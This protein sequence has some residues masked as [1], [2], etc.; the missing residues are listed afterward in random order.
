MAVIILWSSTM[1]HLFTRT[2]KI[3][4]FDRSRVLLQK[5]QKNLLVIA[6]V[7]SRL[8]WSPVV[9]MGDANLCANIY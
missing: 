2:S 1:L 4:Y 5:K 8:L 7:N 9:C 3:D 6:L